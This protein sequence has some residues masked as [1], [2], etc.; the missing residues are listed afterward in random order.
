MNTPVEV[1]NEDTIN[2]LLVSG[3]QYPAKK[4]YAWQRFLLS[5]IAGVPPKMETWLTPAM[6]DTRLLNT[7]YE[8]LYFPN[9]APTPSTVQGVYTFGMELG[10]RYKLTKFSFAM[11]FTISH[12]KGII[13]CQKLPSAHPFATLFNMFA[14]KFANKYANPLESRSFKEYTA[15]IYS[16]IQAYTEDSNDFPADAQ[17]EFLDA[18]DYNQLT[19]DVNNMLEFADEYQDIEKVLA[20]Q[21][22]MLFNLNSMAINRRFPRFFKLFYGEEIPSEYLTVPK[23]STTENSAASSSSSVPSAPSAPSAPST[24]PSQSSQPSMLSNI[25][26]LPSNLSSSN[27]ITPPMDFSKMI[28]MFKRNE[29]LSRPLLRFN[30]ITN[31]YD[32][33]EYTVG[34][35]C[36][37]VRKFPLL[38]NTQTMD[39]TTPT[40]YYVGRID[41]STEKAQTNSYH[42]TGSSTYSTNSRL[43]KRKRSMNGSNGN[44]GDGGDGGDESDEDASTTIKPLDNNVSTYVGEWQ[45][46]L[47][48]GKGTLTFLHPKVGMMKLDGDWIKGSLA[49]TAYTFSF[50]VNFKIQW[51]VVLMDQ[52]GDMTVQ[53][54][55]SSNHIRYLGLHSDRLRNKVPVSHME[56]SFHPLI[57]KGKLN[58]SN[59]PLGFLYDIEWEEN[60]FDDELMNHYMCGVHRRDNNLSGISQLWTG[61]AY[62]HKESSLFNDSMKKHYGQ[63]WMCDNRVFTYCPLV[64]TEHERRILSN[65]SDL[66]F[67]QIDE[68]TINYKRLI[69][70]INS[71]YPENVN[72]G[73]D[74]YTNYNYNEFVIL[75]VIGI[76]M[77]TRRIEWYENV[78]NNMASARS[79]P[80][81]KQWITTMINEYRSNSQS[82]QN[83][84]S[85]REKV[86]LT[87]QSPMQTSVSTTQYTQQVFPDDTGI[88]IMSNRNEHYLFHGTN[89]TYSLASILCDGYRVAQSNTSAR[90]L[91]QGLYLTDHFAKADQYNS[92]ERSLSNNNPTP[93]KDLE[94]RQ[95]TR[96]ALL[97]LLGIYQNLAP[98]GNTSSYDQLLETLGAVNEKHAQTPKT[99]HIMLVFRTVMGVSLQLSRDD[100]YNKN[101]V[102][103][104]TPSGLR[105]IQF[106]LTDAQPNKDSFDY[107][108]RQTEFL[109]EDDMKQGRMKR[110]IDRFDSITLRS[111]KLD[112]RG[113][114]MRYPE[115]V[116]Y[117]DSIG[118]ALPVALILY[119]RNLNNALPYFDVNRRQQVGFSSL[120]SN[121]YDNLRYK[122][123]TVA[124]LDDFLQPL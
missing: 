111:W 66:M 31:T 41:P 74:V 122:V 120:T 35:G 1:I 37:L 27:V 104:E 6:I 52:R 15:F 18:V 24:S 16:V 90:M 63:T 76:S 19:L 43:R 85:T 55:Y 60:E 61:A 119:T 89:S 110:L 69:E 32:F 79:W 46:G 100:E 39:F 36:K 95:A 33:K 65:N 94:R 72:S 112:G 44:G 103:I 7:T 51:K 98:N 105:A 49:Y 91:G 115:H 5:T 88:P 81:T 96:A 9:P 22:M 2:R 30:P 50:G 53:T 92:I 108:Q 23:K 40:A 86:K 68:N 64:Y 28:S 114:H 58:P 3:K 109:V 8:F 57:I 102:N 75:D 59:K 13:A 42:L 21:S 48:H 34:S 80:E 54:P 45:E 71:G 70:M 14:T 117:G 113:L 101:I 84:R 12:L 106:A 62:A 47:F 97:T 56:T 99:I 29:F 124:S 10:Q 121:E 38:S 11:P 123:Q 93:T 78:K 82:D 118:N 83:T 67:Y 73:Q 26:P 4:W 107:N 116:L 77:P 25:T 20:L 17:L 87:T